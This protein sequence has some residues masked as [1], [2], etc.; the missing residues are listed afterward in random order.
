MTST[1]RTS[2][3]P[4]GLEPDLDLP[5]RRARRRSATE[6]PA[7]RARCDARASLRAAEARAADLARAEASLR[8]SGAPVPAAAGLEREA[9]EDARRDRAAVLRALD[10]LPC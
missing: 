6:A 10:L 7:A 2:T 5:A 1:A 9:A 3:R 4:P 8:W